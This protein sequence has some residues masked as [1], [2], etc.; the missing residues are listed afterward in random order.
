MK[1]LAT[2]IL[3]QQERDEQ[4]HLFLAKSHLFLAKFFIVH[5]F[6]ENE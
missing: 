6:L 4:S 2:T 3:Q 1:D 5:T